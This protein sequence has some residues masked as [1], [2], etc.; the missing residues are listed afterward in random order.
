MPRQWTRENLAWLAGL[1]EGEG[2]IVPI[3]DKRRPHLGARWAL[4]LNMADV[5]V[6]KRAHELAGVGTFHV[7]KRGRTHWKTQFMWCVHKREHVYALLVAIWPWL[8]ER[9][10]AR[11]REALLAFGTQP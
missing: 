6:V 10:R 3:R 4:H 7:K 2:S 1:F 9:R 11:A 8:G 5:D